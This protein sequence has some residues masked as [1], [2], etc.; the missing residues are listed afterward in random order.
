MEG[1][2]YTVAG[3]LT[4]AATAGLGALGL[5]TAGFTAGGVVAG[6]AAAAAQAGI[7]S[8]AAGST[9]ALLQSVAATGAIITAL[10]YVAVGGAIAGAAIYVGTQLIWA[11][12]KTQ[13]NKD[14][15]EHQNKWFYIQLYCHISFYLSLFLNLHVF[16]FS[17]LIKSHF[18]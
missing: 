10:P 5:S 14:A 17:Y 7:G 8:V 13:K 16:T 1:L 15:F 6:S 2:L 9:F 11:R 18:I 12:T 4:G 3:S